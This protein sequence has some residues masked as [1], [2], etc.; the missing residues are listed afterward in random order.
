M[1]LGLEKFDYPVGA[2]PVAPVASVL[3]RRPRWTL[4]AFKSS[5]RGLSFAGKT[6]IWLIVQTLVIV[7][8]FSLLINWAFDRG[9]TEYM[10]QFDRSRAVEM[11]HD[12]SAEYAK[13]GS[14]DALLHSPARWAEL[15]M[16]ATGHAGDT[17]Q[18]AAKLE[19]IFAVFH[20][21]EFPA[22]LPAPLPL[23]FLLLD[24]NGRVLIGN[25]R[26]DAK[27]IKT[28]IVVKGERV[29]DMAY[30][31]GLTSTYDVRFRQRFSAALLVVVLGSVLLALGPAILI[32]RH[33]TRPIKAIGGAAR[34]LADGHNDVQLLVVSDD[35][36]GDL[37]R[38]FNS[39]STSLA[40]HESLQ[41]IWLAELSHELRTPISVLTA[42]IEAMLDA[43]R[44]LDR[45]AIQSL[46]EECRRLSRL[47]ED[48]QQLSLSDI[49]A[50]TYNCSRVSLYPLIADCVE[51]MRVR[52]EA[53]AIEVKFRQPQ[54]PVRVVADPDKLRQVFLNLLENSLRYTDQGGRVIVALSGAAGRAR[55]L[56][57]DSSPSVPETEIPHLFERLFR[58]E[59]SRSRKGGG[60]GLGLA[61]VRTIVEAHNGT[62]SARPS[63]LGGLQF[64]IN[65]EAGV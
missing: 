22:A 7:V 55:I 23:R 35:E 15:A 5:R 12:L 52:F 24:R 47:I 21:G 60:A 39:L 41:R 1:A 6:F 57:E 25:P 28:P 61:I 45:R 30:S 33:V 3:R 43:V 10:T 63:A 58:G 62:I 13:S 49:G 20:E 9:I 19:S 27:L 18:D 37:C 29:G 17:T 48:L 34:Q 4:P 53:R 51:S 64:E 56:F 16:K 46:H 59:N 54:R 32:S 31:E 8:A 26:T 2:A 65:L 40:Q 14:W 36:F 38:D 11:A 42:E 44:P 50:V